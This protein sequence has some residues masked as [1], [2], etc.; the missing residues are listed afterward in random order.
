MK[1]LYFLLT[2]CIVVFIVGCGQK[3]PLY[4]PAPQKNT[5]SK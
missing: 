1:K 2:I 3:G 5:S 4:L